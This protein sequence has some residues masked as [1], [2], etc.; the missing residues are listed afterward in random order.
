MQLSPFK[1]LAFI[2]LSAICTGLSAQSDLSLSAGHANALIPG[3][4]MSAGYLSIANA[5][6][7]DARLLAVS[8]DAAAMVQVHESAMSN[9]MMSMRHV[10]TLLIPAGETVQFQP[11]GL[12]LMIMGADQEAFSGESI[13][14]ELQFE[15]GLVL[16]ITLPIKSMVGGHH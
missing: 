8:T 4:E 16:D 14:L 9:G 7:T 10:E 11:G 1:L 6:D 2:A 3:Q 12:H 5:G 15:S 13:D